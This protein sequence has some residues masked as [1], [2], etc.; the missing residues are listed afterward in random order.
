M[1]WLRL[2]ELYALDQLETN[3]V[4]KGDQAVFV[5]AHLMITHPPY[6][7]DSNGGPLPS[8]TVNASEV[9]VA[10]LKSEY[11]DQIK[12]LNK[13]LERIVDT[14]LAESKT[15]PII[16]LQGDHG[17]LTPVREGFDSTPEDKA[18]IM[19]AYYLPHGGEKLLYPSISKS[20]ELFQSGAGLLL[21][22]QVSAPAGH[23]FWVPRQR[24]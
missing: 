12:F 6:L 17:H 9:G 14:I 1:G 18:S 24:R 5:R 20:G 16:I 8:A 2:D 7:F 15:P 10:Q 23:H 13:R 4:P 22:D 11:I 21:R 3:V 19:N